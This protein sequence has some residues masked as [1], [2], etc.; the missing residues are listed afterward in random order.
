MA[1]A[2]VPPLY[3]LRFREIYRKKP[4]GG[5]GLARL[6]KKKGCPPSTGESWEIACRDGTV[7]VVANGPLR[8]WK[9]QKLL[10]RLPREILGDEHSMR[11]SSRFPLLIKFLYA[12]EKLSLQVHPSDDFAARYDDE[13]VGKM[14]AWYILHVEE[15]GRVI[16]GVL[17]G[18][19]VGEFK[20][21][22]QQGTVEQCLNTMVVDPGDVIFIPPGTLHTMF[23]G[24]LLLEV[25][26]NSDVTYRLSDWG[27]KDRN[28]E[29]RPV[30]IERALQV[31]DFYSMGVSK[32]KPARIPGFPYRRKL[33][34]KCEKFTME[35]LEFSSQRVT[36]KADV[37]R[38][39]MYSIVRGRGAFR[40]GLKKNRTEPFKAG[41]TF[42]MPA[43]LGEFDFAARG[44]CE[45]VC[46]FVE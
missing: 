29:A 2:A 44:A 46:T 33:L 9:L 1:K 38:F 3:P 13:G 39:R 30:Q 4:W 23:G 10:D 36:E 8:G 26:Q 43:H 45:V 12:D 40:Y 25:Q 19:T 41:Q 35:S 6:L 5:R 32:Y 42:L 21:H 18:T 28:G 31:V 20:Q 15:T 27:R 7:S 14:E 34:I 16:R 17:P 24:V 11:F 37:A 22:L